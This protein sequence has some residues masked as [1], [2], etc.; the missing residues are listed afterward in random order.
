MLHTHVTRKVK[1]TY[2]TNAVVKLHIR[3]FTIFQASVFTRKG[4][5][6]LVFSLDFLIFIFR[7]LIFLFTMKN[8]ST[9]F[10]YLQ[11]THFI[12]IAQNITELA[13][14]TRKNST[15]ESEKC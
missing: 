7:P 13:T 8:T 15:K 12:D 6:K 4:K 9:G 11:Q 10:Y 3:L 2:L 1:I 14:F 5:K